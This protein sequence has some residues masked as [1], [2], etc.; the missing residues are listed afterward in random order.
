MGMT[1]RTLPALGPQAE[2]GGGGGGG[3]GLGPPHSCTRQTGCCMWCD[4]DD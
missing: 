3:G 2:G 4:G 1:V